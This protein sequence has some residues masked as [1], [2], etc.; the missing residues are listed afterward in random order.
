MKRSDDDIYN[1]NMIHAIRNVQ[2][3]ANLCGKSAIIAIKMTAFV[4]PDILR[5]LNQIFDEQ[6]HTY[7]TSSILDIVSS[8]CN[9]DDCQC[10]INEYRL[11]SF[12]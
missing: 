3:A 8:K 5:K 2:T 9:V 7:E 11:S 12:N 6:Q 1:E 10:F 4:S